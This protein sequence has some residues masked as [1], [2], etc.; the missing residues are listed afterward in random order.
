VAKNPSY[1]LGDFQRA[2]G[3]EPVASGDE[4]WQRLFYNVHGGMLTSLR[5]KLRS[6]A[7]KRVF[8]GLVVDAKAFRS[9]GYQ[10]WGLSVSVYDPGRPGDPVGYFSMPAFGGVTNVGYVHA[11][12]LLLYLD[13]VRAGGDL[14][15]SY[16]A[17]AQRPVSYSWLWEEPARRN[18]AGDAG[19]IDHGFEL[20]SMW[21]Q[22]LVEMAESRK[23]MRVRGVIRRINYLRDMAA[24]SETLF[25]AA[26][27]RILWAGELGAPPPPGALEAVVEEGR[28]SLL[29]IH[30]LAEG[31]Y[32]TLVAAGISVPPLP[33]VNPVGDTAIT[34]GQASAPLKGALGKGIIEGRVLDFGCGRGEDVA[35]LESLGYQVKGYDLEWSPEKPKGMFDTVLLFYVLNVIK[36]AKDRTKVIRDAWRYV[37]DGGSLLVATRTPYDVG[38]QAKKG[39]FHRCSDGWCSSKGTFQ[40]G[41]SNEDLLKMAQKLPGLGSAYAPA[42]GP[43]SFASMMVTKRR[44]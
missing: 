26:R 23:R 27:Y 5:N 24:S 22:S 18:P 34:R 19:D 2:L 21:A 13:Y 31:V 28:E 20:L 14:F 25:R 40:K 36:K 7:A 8:P 11:Y 10:G 16:D 6:V 9:P 1:G 30:A 39:R 41:L 17:V 32:A 35:V 42:A 44:S 33:E 38:R 3:P 12:G 43:G 15:P 29:R 4:L 37:K